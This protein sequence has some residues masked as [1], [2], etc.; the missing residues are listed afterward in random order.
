MK[1]DAG[2][3]T[4]PMLRAEA[5]DIAP[6]ETGASLHDRLAE[7]GARLLIPTLDDYLTGEIQPVPQPEDG[8]TVATRIEKEQGRIDWSKSADEIDRQVRA[9]TPWPGTFTDWG[10]RT[11][12][13][14]SGSSAEGHAE[15]GKVVQSNGRI[16]IGT[17]DGLYLPDRVQLAGKPAVEVQAFVNGYPDFIGATLG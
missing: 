1:M 16:A 17:A 11:L 14:L 12:K 15:P 7:L 10:G 13:V 6:D 3:D 2:L 4:G 8:V 5:I 9:F